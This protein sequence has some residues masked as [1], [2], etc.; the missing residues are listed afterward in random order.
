LSDFN[1]FHARIIAM[2]FHYLFGVTAIA[3]IVPGLAISATCLAY[4]P[5]TFPD[6]GTC[7]SVSAF[8]VDGGVVTIGSPSPPTG[9]STPGPSATSALAGG[10]GLEARASASAD[11]G[12]LRLTATTSDYSGSDGS[13]ASAR[14]AAGFA[15]LGEIVLPGAKAGDLVH[16]TVKVAISGAS[17]GNAGIGPARS[18]LNV[19]WLNSSGGFGGSLFSAEPP[20]GGTFDFTSRVGYSLFVSL[21][22]EVFADATPFFPSAAADY[23]HTTRLFIDFATPGA[24][25]DAV[26]GHDYRSSPVAPSAVPLPASFLLLLAGLGALLTGRKRTKHAWPG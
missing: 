15:D 11:A 23:G 19:A 25:V 13:S 12:L 22:L 5:T 9:G 2:S 6:M 14:A 3:S 20:V 21:G 7:V 1:T 26:S 8:T 17:I 16:G 24:F 18:H 10:A 4:A